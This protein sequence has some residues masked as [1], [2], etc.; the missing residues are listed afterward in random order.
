MT[1]S[2]DT[3]RKRGAIALSELV[4]K[5]LDPVTARRGFV[6]ADLIAGWA[7]IVG[8]RYADCSRPEKIIWPRGAANDGHPGTLIVI[9]EGPRALLLQHEA[10]QIVQRVNASIGHGTIGNVKII[11]GSVETRATPTVKTSQPLALEQES[12]LAAALSE[13]DGENLRSALDRLG[14]AVLAESDKQS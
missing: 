8:A 6:T 13:V 5:A 10:D 9:V 2:N 11:Q 4:G 3:R 7:D 12:S 14:R 1:Q